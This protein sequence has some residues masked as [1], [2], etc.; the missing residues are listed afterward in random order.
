MNNIKPHLFHLIL[1]F[2]ALLGVSFGIVADENKR[3]ALVI[4][5]SDYEYAYLKNPVNDAKALAEALSRLGFETQLLLDADQQTI[6][7]QIDVLGKKIRSG[8]TGLF[9]FAG[10]GVEV[11]GDN[12]LIPVGSQI[13]SEQDVKYKAVALGQVMDRMQFANNSLNIIIL[14]ACRNNPLP[15]S[16]RSG[17]RGLANVDAPKGSIVAYSTAPGSVAADGEGKHS[18]YTRELIAK[19]QTQNLKIEDV[20]KE[21]LRGVHEETAGKQTPW[22]SSS[23]VGDFYF[24]QP[25]SITINQPSI[26]ITPSEPA[27]KI[28]TGSEGCGTVLGEIPKNQSLSFGKTIYVE[29]SNRCNDGEV[30]KVIGGS[31]KRNIPRKYEC[32]ICN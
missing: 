6:E 31:K 1:T 2:L 30:L 14:D 16:V 12:Y 27:D 4:G 18:P 21:V 19:I 32:V 24:T 15:R 23:F 20:F 3:Y 7:K 9:Y 22:V 5:N 28:S 11:S 25:V 8:G 26:P 17:R 13:L 29:N 10:H